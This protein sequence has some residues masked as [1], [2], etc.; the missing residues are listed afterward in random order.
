MLNPKQHFS[1]TQII[2]LNNFEKLTLIFL[3]LAI[4]DGHAISIDCFHESIKLFCG[5]NF[6]K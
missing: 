1:Y 3:T 2:L 5:F 6:K 4:I